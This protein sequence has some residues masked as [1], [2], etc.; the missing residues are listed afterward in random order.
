MTTTRPSVDDPVQQRGRLLLR[1]AA[2]YPDLPVP[3]VLNAVDDAE[4]LIRL[5]GDGAA[6]RETAELVARH[7][8][9]EVRAAVSAAEA[10]GPR[11]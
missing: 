11:A 2:D 1:L 6:E 5:A 10:G 3:L 7:N 8:L 4:R 9:T